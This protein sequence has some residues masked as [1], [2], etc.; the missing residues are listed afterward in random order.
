[1]RYT[2]IAGAG[3]SMSPPSNLPSWWQYNKVIVEIIKELAC[4]LCP[5]AFDLIAAIDIEKG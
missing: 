2:I 5:E 1:M 3:I 4:E